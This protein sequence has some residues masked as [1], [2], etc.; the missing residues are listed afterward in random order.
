MDGGVIAFALL[1]SALTGGV[2]SLAPAFAALRTDL[3]DSLKEGGRTG[4][5]AHSHAWL[6]SALVVA[7]IAVALVLLTVSGAFLRSFQKM[8]STSIAAVRD[9][10]GGRHL[11]PV[12]S[13]AAEEQAWRGGRGYDQQPACLEWRRRCR[14]HH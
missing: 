6:R 11:P 13:G 2:C 9:G 4:N 14:V 12:T 5:S 7:E 1:V 8:V 10:V 3:I